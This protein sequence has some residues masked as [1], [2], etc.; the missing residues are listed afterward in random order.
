MDRT[1]EGMPTGDYL[2]EKK[3]IVPI[4]KV[5]KGL[6][7]EADGVQLMKPIPGLDE[8]LERAISKHIFGTKERSVIKSAN[9]CGIQAIVDQQFEVGSQILSHEL[10]PILEPEVDIKAA[11]KAQCEVL[12]KEALFVGLAKLTEG[13]Q[14]MIKITI[15]TV[16]DF[17]ADLI[18]H[19]KVM[20]VVALSGG[21]TQ[22][23][24]NRL[25]ARNHGLTASFSRALADGLSA[26]Q[27]DAVFNKVLQDSVKAI[28]KASIT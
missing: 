10:V 22:K 5:D 3:G 18:A 4:L 16:D 6:A 1:I 28:Y 15:P 11:D 26:Q 2:W 24:A 9:K 21:Y 7:A 27:D 25:L 14:V 13:Q 19:P 20:R 23:E 17:Y 8:L 12:L